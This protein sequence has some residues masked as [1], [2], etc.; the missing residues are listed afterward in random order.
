MSKP[1]SSTPQRLEFHE[2][3]E[4][5]LL[6][7]GD[8][9]KQFVEDIRTHGQQELITLFEGQVLD[10][11][12]RYNACIAVGIEP[13]TKNFIGTRE[14][15]RDFV[16]SANIHR[17]HLS[18]QD[19]RGIIEKLLKANPE[20]SDRQIA[21]VA[22]VSHPHVG[23]VRAEMEKTGD[24][25]TVSTS[26]DS[27]GRK[28]PRQRGKHAADVPITSQSGTRPDKD[29]ESALSPIAT[30][31]NDIDAENS[32]AARK[33][34]YDASSSETSAEEYTPASWAARS[35]K[36]RKRI[37]SGWGE[38]IVA[39]MLGISPADLSVEMER[40]AAVKLINRANKMAGNDRAV[41]TVI[42]HLNKALEKSKKTNVPKTAL[43]P[44]SPSE[45]VVH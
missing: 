2:L 9:F 4:L 32:A 30:A 31:G 27:R 17:R 45:K 29:G 25:E 8:D 12:N 11:R 43:A 1:E 34:A 42:E 39:E 40:R 7:E 19:K 33:A 3:A 6:L 35:Q 5:F 18:A 10:G 21:E 16:I 41:L 24:V 26:I 36:E 15:A 20:R 14:Q 23:K 44:A 13:E 37:I 28:Q 38:S 22:K